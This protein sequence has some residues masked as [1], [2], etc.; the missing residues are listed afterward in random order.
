MEPLVWALVLSIIQPC[1]PHSHGPETQRDKV[2]L[3]R[4]LVNL[5]VHQNYIPVNR[6]PKTTDTTVLV[7]RRYRRRTM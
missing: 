7:E 3:D 4:K 5:A 1:L 2:E 6:P